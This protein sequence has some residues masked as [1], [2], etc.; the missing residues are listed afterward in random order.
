MLADDSSSWEAQ[1]EGLSQRFRVTVFDNRGVGRSSTPPGSR[2]SVGDFAR[3]ALAVL[4]GMQ[5]GAAHVIGSYLVGHRVSGSVRSRNTSGR[6]SW[7]RSAIGTASATSPQSDLDLWP[8][9]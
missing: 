3:G 4:D 2:W 5:I 7:P 6:R 1:T 9:S 8:G